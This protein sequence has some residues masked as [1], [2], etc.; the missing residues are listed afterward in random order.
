MSNFIDVVL[1]L[2]A[3]SIGIDNILLQAKKYGYKSIFFGDD[4][5]LKLFPNTFNRSEG[6][7]SFYVSDYTEVS[8]LKNFTDRNFNN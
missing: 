6:T 3:D 2:G 1:N 4:T 5:W 7:T 8:K